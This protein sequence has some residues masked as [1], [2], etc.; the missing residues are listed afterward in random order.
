MIPE[1]GQK[2]IEKDKNLCYNLKQETKMRRK[3]DDMHTD[4]QFD[5]QDTKAIKGTAVLMMLFLHLVSLAD[6]YPA[7]FEG[8]VSVIPDL[9]GDGYFIRLITAGMGFCVPLFFFLGGYGLYMRMQKSGFS[10]WQSILKLYKAYWKVFFIFV[11][12]GI[13]FFPGAEKT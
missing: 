10:L 2:R 11:P 5:R 3:A 4:K 6:R 8:F 13:V 12:V 1:S 9:S 7:T